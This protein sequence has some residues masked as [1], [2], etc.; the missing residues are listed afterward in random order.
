MVSFSRWSMVTS[1]NISGAS[2]GILGKSAAICTHTLF[3]RYK[4]PEAE[5]PKARVDS[6]SVSGGEEMAMASAPALDDLMSPAME[7][8]TRRYER[9]RTSA[10][11]DDDPPSYEEAMRN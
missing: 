11:E 9:S 2:V 8:A 4:L 7:M 3:F 10:Q 5:D 1:G 6:W